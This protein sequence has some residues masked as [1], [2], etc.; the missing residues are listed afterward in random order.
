ME[1][2]AA[3]E[4]QGIEKSFGSVHAV[5]GVSLRIEKG[6]ITGIVGENGAGKSTLMSILYGLYHADAGEIR[7]D[8]ARGP[9]G[10]PA[11]CHRPRHRHGAPAFHAGRHLHRAGEPGAG[12]RGRTA[13]GRRPGGGARRAGAAGARVRAFGRSRCA[14]GRPVGRRAAARRDPEGAVPR[15]AH[16]DPRRAQRRADAAGDRPALPH[17]GD[18]E[19]ARRHGRADHPQAARDHGRHR[20]CLCH[21]PGPDRGRP[22]HGRDQS[23]G[24]GRADGRPQGADCSS[25]RRRRSRAR[26]CCKPST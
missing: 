10:K 5:R 18:A 22:P 16:P 8:G 25:T 1:A 7:V 19:G 13:A 24:A 3:I 17:P 12:R 6:A 4:L 9:H 23:R 20:P 2:A 15:R 14:G 26:C 21:A 11:R